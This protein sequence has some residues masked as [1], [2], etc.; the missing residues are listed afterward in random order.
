MILKVV[1]FTFTNLQR[2][3]VNLST[4]VNSVMNVSVPLVRITMLKTIEIEEAARNAKKK[5]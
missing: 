4:S 5:F 1:R 2:I 3:E